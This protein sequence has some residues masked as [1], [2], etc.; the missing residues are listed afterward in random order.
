MNL[1]TTSRPHAIGGR[2]LRR[3][4]LLAA[5]A[6]LALCLIFGVATRATSA[7]GDADDRLRKALSATAQ[8]E[9]LLTLHVAANTDFLKG[10]GSAGY[11]SRA[12]PIWRAAAVAGAYDRLEE[13]YADESRA[14]ARLRELRRLSAAWPLELDAA[15]RNIATAGAATPMA[16]GLL[17]NSNETLSS[18]MT[19]LTTL[20]SQERDAI[21]Q[22]QIAAQTQLFR[23]KVSLAVASALGL[24]L[25]FAALFMSHRAALADATSRIV[26]YEAE[27]RFREYFENHPVAM[28]IFDLQT[29]QI[30]MAN[31]AAQRQYG[32]SLEELRAMKI[33]EL[34]PAADVETFRR[35]LK[36]LVESGVR[37]GSGG[38]RRHRRMDGGTIFVDISFHLLDYAGRNACFISARDV[39][40]HEQAKEHLRVRSSALEASRNA[41]LITRKSGGRSIITYANAAFERITGYP[42]HEAIGAEHWSVLGCD[43]RAPGPRSIEAAVQ[44]DGESAALLESHRRDGSPYW[45]QLQVAPVLDANGRPTHSVTVFSDV[46][47]RVRYQEQLRTLAHEDPLTHLPNRLGLTARI[48]RMFARAS[49]DGQRLALVFF[50][51]DNFKEINDTLGHNAGDAVLREVGRRLAAYASEEELVARYAGDEFVAVLYG[52]GDADDFVAAAKRMQ[53]RLADDFVVDN[54]VIGPHACVGIALFPDD[55]QDPET[56][57]KYADAAMYRAKSIGPDSLQIFH[58]SIALENSERAALAQDLRRAVASGEFTLAYQPRL[59]LASG[60]VNGFEALLR[61]NHA[62]R[63]PIS[64]AV[65]IPIAEEN[66]LIVQIGEWVL[67]Q[68]CRQTRI[69]ARQYPDIVVAVNVSPVQFVRSDLLGL[70]ESIFERTG[71]NPRNIELEIT[72]GALM[73]PRSMT[74]LRALRELGVCVA[75][76]DFGS[77]Y[78]SL[79][80]LRSFMADRVKLDMSFVQGIGI[81]R[82][83]EV[84]AKAVFAMGRTLGMHVVAEGVETPE[85]L[86]FLIEHGCDEIQGYW[87][88]RPTDAETARTYL[89]ASSYRALVERV[90]KQREVR[91]GGPTAVVG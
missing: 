61:W 34:R 47:E 35:D 69:W 53:A 44:A 59:S 80:Y 60:A 91:I 14:L 64:P 62:R 37:G 18:I 85:Q 74:T 20:R 10:V 23:Q 43:M 71:A 75:I 86:E 7:R 49:R 83:D 89:E 13:S 48:E 12:W 28:L 15:A 21:A 31:T 76:D 67:E 2:H 30:L 38:M 41:V 26:A 54:K 55:S 57:L 52:R 11:S 78:S 25:L 73:T 8:L 9:A 68:A 63:G 84:I 66:G 6:T 42:A 32:A 82:A 5:L 70:V 40:S 22:M 39:T 65:F 45:S 50:D 81:S 51:L 17:Q 29:Y 19:I 56:L 72:E 1:A 3:S 24:L 58:Q 87:F 27:R 79:G 4:A 16:V 36:E 88:A 90:T 46:S 33:H 77:G